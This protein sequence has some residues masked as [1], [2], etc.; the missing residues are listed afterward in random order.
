MSLEAAE[1]ECVAGKKQSAHA[2]AH[3]LFWAEL[4]RQAGRLRFCRNYPTGPYVHD[5][6]CLSAR[7]AVTLDDGAAS[8]DFE[9]ERRNWL[10]RVNIH[11][12]SVPAV[13]L[14]Q[15]CQRVAAEVVALARIR[16]PGACTI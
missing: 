7:L 2:Y 8:P 10:E 16:T 15:D 9:S 1:N 12:V 5:F 14:L 13:N 4:R 6:Y 11:L 3:A